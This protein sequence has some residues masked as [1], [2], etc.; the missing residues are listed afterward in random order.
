M[1]LNQRLN[2]DILLFSFDVIL[3]IFTVAQEQTSAG[4]SFTTAAEFSTTLN[5]VFS[6]PF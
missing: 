5:T 1:I 4:A 6:S 3:L 2:A